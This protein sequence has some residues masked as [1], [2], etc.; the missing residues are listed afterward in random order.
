[1]CFW[2]SRELDDL[3]LIRLD[4]E[5]VASQRPRGC[6][7]RQRLKCELTNEMLANLAEDVDVDERRLVN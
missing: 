7:V 3:D 1:M 5:V 4:L 2:F 6:K